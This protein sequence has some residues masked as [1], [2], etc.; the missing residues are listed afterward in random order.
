[1][2]ALFIIGTQ[3]LLKYEPHTHIRHETTCCLRGFPSTSGSFGL[4]VYSEHPI[5]FGIL[6]KAVDLLPNTSRRTNASTLS[7]S[8]AMLINDIHTRWSLRVAVEGDEAKDS[9]LERQPELL[10]SF[11]YLFICNWKKS[12]G[13]V[14]LHRDNFER[15]LGKIES[16]IFV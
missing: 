8:G 10:W 16:T 7:A 13:C 15:R 4:S 9:S 6:L 12:K 1:M 3:S 5:E 11:F 14:R 2:N